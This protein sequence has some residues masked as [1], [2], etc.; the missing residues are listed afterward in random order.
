M[1]KLF[2][3]ILRHS[4]C[5]TEKNVDLSTHFIKTELLPSSNW[6]VSVGW[7]FF[8]CFS[9]LHNVSANATQICL[10]HF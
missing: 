6:Y 5:P 1:N 10:I 2:S 3:A 9:Y 7:F 4:L 8:F